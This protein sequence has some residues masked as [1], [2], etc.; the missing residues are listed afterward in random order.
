MV[1][2]KPGFKPFIEKVGV[3]ICHLFSEEHPLIDYGTAAQRT[4]VELWNVFIDHLI[5]NPAPDDIEIALE[6]FIRFTGLASNHNLFN[7]GPRGIRFFTDDAYVQRHLAPSIDRITKLQNLR[8]NNTAA[9]FLT[10]EICTWQ[11]DHANGDRTWAGCMTG[12]NGM[13]VEK[14]LRNVI[15]NERFV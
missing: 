10:P 14:S 7:F 3:K 8:F 13:L 15:K 12:S 5:L 11:K 1:N 2:R 9:A 6:I 4:D